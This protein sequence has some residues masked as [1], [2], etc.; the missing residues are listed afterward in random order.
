M[1]QA[2][3]VID[4]QLNMFDEKLKL[5]R[6]TEILSLIARMLSEAHKSGVTVVYLQNGGGPEDPDQRGTEG[7]KIHPAVT[8]IEGDIVVP[9]S[10]PDGFHNTDL[11]KQLANLGAEEL[12]VV[13]I[14]SELCID[15]TCRSAR[16]KGYNVTLV[17]DG[18]TT[19]D[20]GTQTAEEAIRSVNASL[21]G[22]VKLKRAE[23]TDFS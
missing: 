18:H 16:S 1:K 4:T 20:Q 22:V 6:A 2:L 17:Q 12:I 7:W 15:A 21:A 14:Q 8:P 23:E 10:G 5:Y 19:F 13:G 3:L 9:K 11:Q